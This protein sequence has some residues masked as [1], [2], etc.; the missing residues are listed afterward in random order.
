MRRIPLIKYF[1]L[2]KFILYSSVY[3]GFKSIHCLFCNWIAVLQKQRL[4]CMQRKKRRKRK[5]LKETSRLINL[6]L[7]SPSTFE[8]H[9]LPLDSHRR[10]PTPSGIG[11]FPYQITIHLSWTRGICHGLCASVN[12]PAPLGHSLIP[13]TR[14]P[15]SIFFD[16]VNIIKE[17]FD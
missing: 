17:N 14:N 11:I 12:N 3:I 1:H 5:H 8:V 6:Y 15:T 7:L 9:Q 4:L 16:M 10:H 2:S 13:T